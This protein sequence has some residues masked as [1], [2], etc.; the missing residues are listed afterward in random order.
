MGGED[1]LYELAARLGAISRHDR[2]GWILWQDGFEEGM[3]KWIAG[4][5]G[6]GSIVTLDGTF[7]R[8]GAWSA[9]LTA[10]SDAGSMASI[11]RILPF[12]LL[13]RMGFECS[14][15]LDSD[16]STLELRANV[17]DGTNKHVANVRYDYVNK[18]LQYLNASNAWVDIA[19]SV[20]LVRADY[21]FWTWK[22]V[23]DFGEEELV[24]LIVNDQYYSLADIAYYKVADATINQVQLVI[25]N[26]ATAGNNGIVYIDDVIV[27]R[28]EP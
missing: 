27:T 18:K 4:A 5:S 20:D 26:V 7:A 23:A 12:P 15:A 17:F 16:L 9:K 24:R 3:F 28:N 11:A 13:G 22:L 6:T 8:S 19:A 1:A 25:I 10:G 14:F 21:P 2:H